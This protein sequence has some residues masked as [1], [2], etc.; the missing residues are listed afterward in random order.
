MLGSDAEQSISRPEMLGSGP[1]QSISRPEMRCS[2]PWPG[3]HPGGL[4]SHVPM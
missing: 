3:E 4:A 1:E 2:E